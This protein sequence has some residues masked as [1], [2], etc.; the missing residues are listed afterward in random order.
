M[1]IDPKK[2]EE[3]EALVAITREADK[4][5]AREAGNESFFT[6]VLEAL[7]ILLSERK[8]MLDLLRE[9][10]W[11]GRDGGPLTDERCCP[12]CD[13]ERGCGGHQADCRLAA[14]LK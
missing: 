12:V 5:G 7:P 4:V 6:M 8:E 10:Q 1:R 9:I 14:F 11:R 3:W 13:E 2:I